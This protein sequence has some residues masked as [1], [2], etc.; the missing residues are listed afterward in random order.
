MREQ[1]GDVSGGV[2]HVNKCEMGFAFVLDRLR[3]Q[4][5]Q[6]KGLSLGNKTAEAESESCGVNE[7]DLPENGK[8]GEKA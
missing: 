3:K 2:G 7:L 8:E 6:C 1:T 4:S 5:M